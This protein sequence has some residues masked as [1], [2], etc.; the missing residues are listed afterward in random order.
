MSSTLS[1]AARGL[2]AHRSF[3]FYFG[4]R[5]L[6]EFAY[7][8]CAVAVGWQIY[9]LTG[10]ALA[11]GLTGLAEFAPTAILTFAA[12]HVADRFERRRVAQACQIV[13][14][15]TAA[16]LAWGSFAGWLTA[17]Q[18]FLAVAL[19]GAAAAFEGPAA[20]ALLPA[21]APTGG[22]QRA[23]TLCGGAMQVATIAAPIVGGLA[24]ARGAAAPY[25]LMAALWGIAA[26]ANGG[27]RPRRPA[28]PPDPPRLGAIFHGV[29]FVRR[30]PALLGTISLDL[31]AVLLGGATTLMPIFARDILHVGPWGL[32]LLRAAPAAGALVTTAVLLR[33]PIRRA[34]GLRM[35]AAV[36]VFGLATAVF[37]VSRSLP[38][39]LLA[40]VALG[41]ADAVSM[42]IRGA[43]VQLATPDAMRGRVGAVNSLF[44]GASY[45]LGGF[46]SGVAASLLGAAPAAL[47]GGLGTI[48]VA[49]LWMRLFPTLRQVERLD[50]HG[51]HR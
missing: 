6:S 33:R 45:Q 25:A 36:I 18:I 39:S 11:L 30:N 35:F 8:I 9:A 16:G 19:I 32:G 23:V 22:L 42:V 5:S 4:A 44:V 26:L 13:S 17:P 38:L 28:E 49:L 40:L 46:E 51:D 47:L 2:L 15:L 31:F 48:A 37:A 41:G 7:Q 3:V 34:A 43:L 20:A 14:A 12:G 27:V 1:A 21:V 50:Q 24:G 10:S 29:A